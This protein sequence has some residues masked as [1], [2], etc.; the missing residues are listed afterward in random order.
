VAASAVT[1]SIRR[2][3]RLTNR[4][5]IASGIVGVESRSSFTGAP[6]ALPVNEK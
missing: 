5:S 3:R 6:A 2:Y 1:M 4:N